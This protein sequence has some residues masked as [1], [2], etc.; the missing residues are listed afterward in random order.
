M[1]ISNNDTEKQMNHV[2]YMEIAI[3]QA[4]KAHKKGE[5]PVGAVLVNEDGK[6]LSASHNQPITLSDPTAHAEILVL[7]EAA[8]RAQNYRLLSTVLYVTVEPCVMCMGAIIHARVSTLVF[9][10]KDSK[11]GA[12]GSLYHFAQD[13]RLNHRPQVIGGICQNTCRQLMQDFFKF[14][15]MHK[16]I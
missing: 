13:D 5:V 10:T 4:R 7:R 3:Q 11:W 14:K 6:I 16:I 15:R 1:N 8:V 9:G 12:A 2:D